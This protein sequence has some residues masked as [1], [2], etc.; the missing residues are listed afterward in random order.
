MPVLPMYVRRIYARDCAVHSHD[1]LE[2]GTGW[3]HSTVVRC[4]DDVLLT[5]TVRVLSIGGT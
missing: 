5:C 4:S 2:R 3:I 1:H